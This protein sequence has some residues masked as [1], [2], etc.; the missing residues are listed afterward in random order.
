MAYDLV[1]HRQTPRNYARGDEIAYT[2]PLT[3]GQ[4]TLR[5]F[6]I[7]ALGLTSA[8]ATSYP[9]IR[10]QHDRRRYLKE[11]NDDPRITRK[12]PIVSDATAIRHLKSS[13]PHTPPRRRY[14]PIPLN[15]IPK[16]QYS[17]DLAST[18]ETPAISMYDLVSK[19]L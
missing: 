11:F 17:K 19:K 1:I 6:A 9:Q 12:M 13:H 18:Q 16:R 7:M 10:K 8:L 14:T 3:P 4:S 15:D 2:P 5:N